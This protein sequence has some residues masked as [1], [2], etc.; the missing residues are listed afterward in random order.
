MFFA[1]E[2][3]EREKELLVTFSPHINVLSYIE[4]R[5]REKRTSSHAELS[6]QCY[7]N[8]EQRKREKSSCHIQ[9]SYKCSFI[10][11]TREKRKKNFLSSCALA[12][13]LFRFPGYLT[14][15]L[16]LPGRNSN[17]WLIKIC[18]R[19]P[20]PSSS[21][22]LILT[23]E[24]QQNQMPVLLFWIELKFHYRSG[25]WSK[26]HCLSCKIQLTIFC[27]ENAIF[28]LRCWLVS[29]SPQPILAKNY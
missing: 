12:S 28:G 18:F 10:Y 6:H 9:L 11:W 5:K 22:V 20:I 2:K 29:D 17:I 24:I 21:A 26:F 8:T 4:Q 27:V 1:E 25:I 14:W 15:G 7:L 19:F 16:S 3:I 23:S 13:L